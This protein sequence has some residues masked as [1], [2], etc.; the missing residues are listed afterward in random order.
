MIEELAWS[1]CNFIELEEAVREEFKE[2]VELRKLVE[3][4]ELDQKRINIPFMMILQQLI[5]FS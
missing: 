5:N 3:A 1:M 2:Q 4:L